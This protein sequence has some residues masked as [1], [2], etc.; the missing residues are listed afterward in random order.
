MKEYLFRGKRKDNGEWVYGSLICNEDHI[1]KHPRY[2]IRNNLAYDWDE[3]DEVIPETVGMYIQRACYNI[4]EVKI[5]EG[6]IIKITSGRKW[7]NGIKDDFSIAI[8]VD[9]HSITENGS[10]QWFPQDT[11]CVIE[12]I[13][14]VHDNPELVG[15]KEANIYKNCF[16]LEV[17]E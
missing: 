11:L 7:A 2:F 17:T 1:Y 3:I 12:V 14:N 8:V 6:D 10:G 15:E 5:F 4:E 16:C 13:G 9:E